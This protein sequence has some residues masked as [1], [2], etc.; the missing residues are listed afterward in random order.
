MVCRMRH[1]SLAMEGREVGKEG[2]VA[3][4]FRPLAWASK[5]GKGM[6]RGGWFLPS[7][8]A[9]VKRDGG[10]CVGTRGTFVH[11]PTCGA[12]EPNSRKDKM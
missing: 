5:E 8:S 6:G 7:D 1:C 11:V 10:G 3:T 4:S 2:R 9:S 12:A